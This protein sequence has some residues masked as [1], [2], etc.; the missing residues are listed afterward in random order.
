[1]ESTQYIVLSGSECVDDLGKILG[2]I[3][4]PNPVAISY[5]N[6]AYPLNNLFVEPLVVALKGSGVK[7]VATLFAE[8]HQIDQLRKVGLEHGVSVFEN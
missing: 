5:R 1:M 7:E 6:A 3:K 2:K 4:L 8:P